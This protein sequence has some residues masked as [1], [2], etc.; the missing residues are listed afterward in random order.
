METMLFVVFFGVTKW[1][2]SKQNVLLPR[3]LNEDTLFL[4]TKSHTSAL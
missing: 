1:A 3:W 2:E 4:K